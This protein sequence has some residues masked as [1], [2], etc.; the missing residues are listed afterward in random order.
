MLS[1]QA[2][3]KA[4]QKGY[5]YAP[6][7]EITTLLGQ[8]PGP[9]LPSVPI[10]Q[11]WNY[12]AQGI[13]ALPTSS[14]V[15]P[16][17]GFKRIAQRIQVGQEMAQKRDSPNRSVEPGDRSP[18]QKQRKPRGRQPAANSASPVRP[19]AKREPTPDQT[20][21]LQSLRQATASPTREG[22]NQPSD[23][24]PS[25][26]VPH[27]VS[28]DSSPDTHPPQQRRL[29]VMSNS[30]LYPSPLKRVGDHRDAPIGST[31]DRQGSVDNASEVSWNLERDIHEDDLQRT[32]P[33]KYRGEPHGRNITAPPRR[34][35]G[36][37]I[38]QETIEEE[39]E[40]ENESAMDHEVEAVAD[41]V[42]ETWTAPARTIIPQLF[43][44]SRTP[45]H[46]ADP[47]SPK[48]GFV[49]RWVSSLK[50]EIRDGQTLQ[51]PSRTN[52]IRVAA[53][54]I[55]SLLLV[56]SYQSG[57]LQ[58][59]HFP[60]PLRDSSLQLPPNITESEIFYGLRNQMSSVN[61]EVSS[62]SRELKS[63][64]SEHTRDNRPTYAVDPITVPKPTPRVN[65][66]SPALGAIILPGSTT[67]TT[68][69]R[70]GWFE[71]VLGKFLSPGSS[72][73]R[74]PLP[75]VAALLPWED[76]GDCW[77]STPRNGV[78]QLAVSLNQKIVPE[79][80]IVEHIP[81]GATLTPGSA[82]RNIEMWARFVIVPMNSTSKEKSW[83]PW[84]SPQTPQSAKPLPARE[85]GLGGYNMPGEATLHDVLMN[86]LRV[87]HPSED[88]SAYS[89]D[90][91]LGPNFYRVGWMEY[92]IHKEN[93]IQRFSLNTVIDIPTI[94]VDM[95]VFRV[96]SNW[97][98][99]S[100]CIYRLKLHGHV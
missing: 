22:P 69:R 92:D 38:V 4:A 85:T 28:T 30:P 93:N 18:S 66:L 61:A 99:N 44:R 55:L 40:E 16:N 54:L 83:A 58:K 15:D 100:T 6:E 63:V 37:A 64:R 53:I 76:V 8:S 80:L 36:L 56:F 27:A 2:G 68:G 73:G 87:S 91:M 42:P 96:T 32:R 88:A 70:P 74:G 67:P 65:F 10:A 95:V 57:Y 82:P 35:S 84:H 72:L 59:L 20:Q 89:D 12:G 41:P 24:T 33:S 3:R 26:P 51:P 52:W 45:E 50:P 34:P 75:P 5:T 14:P 31:P 48:D 29:S 90:P 46:I 25:P 77:C 71:R 23:T 13:T 43:R 11:S 81:A 98:S 47:L 86:S 94:R 19:R 79:E 97:G 60:L 78:N 7:D 9:P 62:L 21:L 49:E 1:K 17:S 39:E